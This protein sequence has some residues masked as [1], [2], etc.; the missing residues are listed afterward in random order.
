MLCILQYANKRFFI[1]APSFSIMFKFSFRIRHHHCAET[2]LSLRFPKH[3]ITVIDI[4]SQSPKEKQYFYY[5][6]GKSSDFDAILATLQKSKSYKLAKEVERSKDTLLLLVVLYQVG[7]VQN[8][9][10][11]HHGFF[12]DHHTVYEGYEYWHVG[13]LDRNSIADMKKAIHRVGDLKVLYIGEVEF[14]HTLLSPQ[15][16]K[17]FRYAYEQGYYEIPRKITI[18]RIAKSLKLNHATTG[19]HLLKAEN[20]IIKSVG[21]RL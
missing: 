17:V 16:K 13:V 6:T 1:L 5:I 8:L 2:A 10:Q 19:E 4:Q 9:I 7:Y 12:L 14:A 20:K 3:Y 18:D 11:K 21:R 15:Q